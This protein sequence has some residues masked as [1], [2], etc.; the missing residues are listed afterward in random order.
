VRDHITW[1]DVFRSLPP[2]RQKE[3]CEWD[4]WY[5]LLREEPDRGAVIVGAEFLSQL[6]ARLVI[7]AC[8]DP[9]YAEKDLFGN[10]AHSIASSLSSRLAI[11]RAMGMIGPDLFN[12]LT[13]I[14]K[15]RND[16]AHSWDSFSFE[17]SSTR[18]HCTKL[19]VHPA[20]EDAGWPLRVRFDVSIALSCGELST[21]IR[22]VKPIAWWPS[23]LELS[24]LD[25]DGRKLQLDRMR[26]L[27]EGAQGH[28]RIWFPYR[29]SGPGGAEVP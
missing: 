27:H 23:M 7:A 18:E 17:N 6:L 25:E 11:C 21:L 9:K 3:I 20:M 10:G 22:N 13:R 2:E 24:M 16:A 28:P 8:A 12:Q 19:W 14:R 4:Q 15:I 26:A 29:S 1:S 5:N